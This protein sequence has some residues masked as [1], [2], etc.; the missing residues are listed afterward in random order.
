MIWLQNRSRLL[1]KAGATEA[2]RLLEGEQPGP[3][4]P[5]PCRALEPALGEIFL[6]PQCLCEFWG[7]E[8]KPEIQSIKSKANLLDGKTKQQGRREWD[9]AAW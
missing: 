4:K 2:R 1:R 3:G 6:G 8:R 5:S 9:S 7:S